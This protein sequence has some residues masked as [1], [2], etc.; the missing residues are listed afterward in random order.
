MAYSGRF[1]PTNP[2]KYRGDV[3]NI[4]Y[5]SLWERKAMD[6]FDRNESILEWSSEELIIPYISPLDNK[7]HR[8][9]PDFVIK[10]KA[11]DGSIKKFVI[12]VK[13]EKQTKPPEKAKRATKRVITEIATW[14]VNEAKWKAATEFCLDRGWQFKIIT[15]KELNIK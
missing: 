1:F 3:T 14:G 5:R 6:W 10:A 11:R 4:W 12:E 7:Y 13:P 9:F 8:Y 2:K 15:E